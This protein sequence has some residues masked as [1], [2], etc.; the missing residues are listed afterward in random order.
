MNDLNRMAA[1]PTQIAAV[2]ASPVVSGSQGQKNGNELPPVVQAAK[3]RLESGMGG[4][5]SPEQLQE[6][7]SAAVAHMNEYVQS[8]QR[9]LQ[10]SLDANSGATVVKV[11]DRKT[12]ELIRQI[13]DETFLRIAQSLSVEEPLRLLSV[14]A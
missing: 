12:Q 10:F 7:L 5:V 1:L 8:T 9:D 3:T 2:S 6:K 4:A 14:E 13:P 11:L